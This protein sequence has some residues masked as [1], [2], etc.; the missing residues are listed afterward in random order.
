MILELRLLDLFVRESCDEL[1][2]DLVEQGCF[3]TFDKRDM[4]VSLMC[5]VS[6]SGTLSVHSL[7]SGVFQ[8]NLMVPLSSL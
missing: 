5:K 2:S 8:M 7:Y 1:L 6:A 3:L 4:G